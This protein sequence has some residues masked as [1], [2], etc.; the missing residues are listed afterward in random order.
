MT[1]YLVLIREN[2]SNLEEYEKKYRH[3]V[4][5]SFKGRDATP[6]AQSRTSGMMVLEGPEIEGMAITAF[7]TMADAKAWFDSPEYQ[8]ARRGRE[9]IANCRILVCEGTSVEEVQG[10]H[11]PGDKPGKGA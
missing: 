8:A 4:P 2:I 11:S 5:A 10:F 7:P 1:A 3:L 6:V 9:G